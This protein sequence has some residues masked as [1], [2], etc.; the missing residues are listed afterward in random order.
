MV[1]LIVDDIKL[2]YSQQ[3]EEPIRLLSLP[4]SAFFPDS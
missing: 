1:R 3:K 2:I 4:S